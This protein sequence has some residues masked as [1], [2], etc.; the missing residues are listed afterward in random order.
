[1]TIWLVVILKTF[2]VVY[3]SKK[4]TFKVVSPYHEAFILK[5][6]TTLKLYNFHMCDM[7][8]TY[9]LRML[10]HAEGGRGEWRGYHHNGINLFTTIQMSLH[11]SSPTVLL[12]YAPSWRNDSSYNWWTN[13]LEVS[14]EWEESEPAEPWTE[15]EELPCRSSACFR[16]SFRLRLL[17]A[18]RLTQPGGRGGGGGGFR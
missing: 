5:I 6:K 18:R 8:K 17:S 7:F 3:V 13:E 16:R 2:K 9:F 11:V 10:W 12:I 4:K 14:S 1:M 15:S